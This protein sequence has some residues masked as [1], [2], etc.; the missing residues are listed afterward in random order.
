M[1]VAV[2]S[3]SQDSADAFGDEVDIVNRRGSY[4]AL[5]C[6]PEVDG[7]YVAT[8]HPMRHSNARLALEHGK[9]VLVEKAFTTTSE[10]AR[11]LV[12]LAARNIAC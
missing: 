11:E 8:P 10:Q 2:R 4:E 3:R 1:I 12:A 7:V 9:S 5:V 6:D